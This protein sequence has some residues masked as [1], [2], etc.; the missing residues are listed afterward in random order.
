[1]EWWNHGR[2]Q[3]SANIVWAPFQ[4]H[5]P[6]DFSSL[7]LKPVYI[8][9]CYLQ[10]TKLATRILSKL[11]IRVQVL[12]IHTLTIYN[13]L[14][15]ASW[16]SVGTWNIVAGWI[17]GCALVIG[18]QGLY[19][20]QGTETT[21]EAFVFFFPFFVYMEQNVWQLA[22]LGW[23]TAAPWCHQEPTPFCISTLPSLGCSFGLH[24]YKKA[25]A[26]PG[27]LSEF[28][29]GRERKGW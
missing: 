25:A 2:R 18:R 5:W 12:C 17:R 24:G 23:S 3:D 4:F 22:I 29:S 19:S 26:T 11:F 27:S 28:Q 20:V 8:G 1:M 7:F 21:R 13:L 9:F 16:L 14:T 15:W 6:I 10:L